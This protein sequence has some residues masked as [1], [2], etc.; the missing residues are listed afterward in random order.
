MPILFSD[1]QLSREILILL[2]LDATLADSQ[3]S[4][5]FQAEPRLTGRFCEKLLSFL[6][7]QN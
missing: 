5:F 6:P 1:L 3:Q 4:N 7:D 2:G